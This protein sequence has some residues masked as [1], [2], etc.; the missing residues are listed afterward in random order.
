[1]KTNPSADMKKEKT[2]RE[3]KK[4]QKKEARHWDKN[5]ADTFP[6]SDPVAKY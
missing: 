3:D 5:V 1:M 6:A 4:I 2:N